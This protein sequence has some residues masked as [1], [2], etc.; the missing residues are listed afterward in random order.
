VVTKADYGKRE[1]EAGR[2][3]LIELVHL[4]GEVRDSMVLV[5]G[6]VPPLL[7][8]ETAG[9]YVGTL[10]VDLALNHLTVD[11]E[12]YQ[13]IR[14][15][16]IKRGYREGA[17]PFI[18]HR[19][20]PMEGGDPVVVE[21]NFLSGEYG[22]TGKT[23]RTQK[24]QDIHARKARGCDLAFDEYINVEVE[25]ELPGGGVDRVTCRIA[26]VVPFIVMK[27]MALADRIKEKDAWDIYYCLIHHPGGLD[28]LAKDFKPR[29]GNGLVAESLAK[30][31]EKFASPLHV[32]PRHVAD[33][34]GVT[35]TEEREAIQRDAFERMS[36]LFEK[37]G[38]Q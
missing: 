38:L 5:G 12:T 27:G 6:S 25:G 30:I 24:V 33:F 2:S 28:A 34:E 7:Y 11:E 18:F 36:Y 1:I 9:D 8:P 16:L 21:V 32:G 37:L 17:Q 29:V 4:L 14:N 26:A 13:T 19:D 35:D 23:H 15:A 10:D 31:S 22:G 3:V 20:V